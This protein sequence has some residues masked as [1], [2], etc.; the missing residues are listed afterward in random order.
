MLLTPSVNIFFKKN[1]SSMCFEVTRCISIIEPSFSVIHR[2]IKT[3]KDSV[4]FVV[5][6][7]PPKYTLE[8]EPH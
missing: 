8:D 6:F 5:C 7:F 2:K 1:I 3:P 4:G